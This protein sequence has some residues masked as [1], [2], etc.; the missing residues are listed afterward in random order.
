MEVA[1]LILVILCLLSIT[2]GIGL[3]AYFQKDREDIQMLKIKADN[4]E[5]SK[6]IS[7]LIAE[8]KIAEVNVGLAQQNAALTAKHKE[9]RQMFALS[10]EVLQEDT[11]WLRSSFFQRFGS[12]PEYQDL[13]SQIISFQTKLNQIKNTL[14]EFRM[15]EDY[16]E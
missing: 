3:I 4:E 14:R 16:D 10:F 7:S 11:E 15:I 8:L 12:V 13:N 9:Y 6:S 5:L 2:C 1:I